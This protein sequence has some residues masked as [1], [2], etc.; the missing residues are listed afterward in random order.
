MNQR[1]TILR[2]LVAVGWLAFL[3][4]AANAVAPCCGITGISAD[5]LVTAQETGSKRVFQ[6]Q[7]NDKALL[8]SLHVGQAIHADF[9]TQKVSVDGIQPCCSIVSGAATS[10]ISTA[11]QPAQPC[12][13]ITGMANGLVTAQETGS[14]RVFQ[15]QVNDKALLSS[16]HVGQTIHADFGTQKVSVDGITPC[17]SIV[18]GG[19]AAA[20]STAAQPLT[21]CCNIVANAAL[22]GRLGRLVIAFPEGANAS[23]AHVVVSTAQDQKEIANAYGNQSLDLLPGTYA[24]SVNNMRV[25]GVTIQAGHDTQLKVGVLRVSAADA[26]RVRVLAADQT[27]ELTSTYG[28]QELGFPVGT[29]YVEVA[30]Q[31]EA[32]TIAEGKITNF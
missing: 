2:S 26:T 8:V 20:I 6:F 30:G 4:P 28:K 21:P 23:G 5:G 17:C 3:S 10:A 16:L 12:C 14:A 9:G 25:D 22:T 15:F 7:V 24:V 18:S 1:H 32:V 31:R 29:V 27:H 13:N 19:A 11:A